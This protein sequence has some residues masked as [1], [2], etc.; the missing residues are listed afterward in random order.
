M[1]RTPKK[2][3]AKLAPKLEKRHLALPSKV[4]ILTG[5]PF[6]LLITYSI[7]ALLFI[8]FWIGHSVRLFFSFLLKLLISFSHKFP[9]TKDFKI[10]TLRL[11]LRA[12]RIPKLPIPKVNKKILAI[13][14]FIILF[15]FGFWLIVLKGL[16]SP[17]EL[18]TR[19][20]EISTKIY[21]RNGELLFKIYKDQNRTPVSLD[22]IPIHVRLATLAAEDAEF[23]QHLGFSIRGIIRAMIRNATQ[24]EL[25]GGSTITQQ[26][27]K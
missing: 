21:D 13:L 5:K 27:V 12:L 17:E 2:A 18:I 6:Y 20:Q 8:S 1:A 9:K 19:D 24:G 3:N 7:L 26:L 22:Q 15:A 11:R 16:P 14:I 10:F 4:L 25:T 23:Y